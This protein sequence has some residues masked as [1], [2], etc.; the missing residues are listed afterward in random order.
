MSQTQ[1]DKVKVKDNDNGVS[2]GVSSGVS[3]G[4]SSHQRPKIRPPAS[5]LPLGSHSPLSLSRPKLTSN[6]VP[7]SPSVYPEP[8]LVQCREYLEMYQKIQFLEQEKNQLLKDENQ[9]NQYVK[10]LHHKLRETDSCISSLLSQLQLGQTRPRHPER[11][12]IYLSGLMGLG[13]GIIL[14]QGLGYFRKK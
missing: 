9:F 8:P 10:T 11:S 6:S 5:P 13:F 12:G 3:G 2:G 7:S 4:V 1:L 14:T